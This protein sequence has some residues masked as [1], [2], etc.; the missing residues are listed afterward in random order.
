MPSVASPAPRPLSIPVPATLLRRHAF[1]SG[2]WPERL[3]S[4]IAVGGVLLSILLNFPV[5]TW[6]GSGSDF[7]TMYAS[8]SLLARGIDGYSFQNIAQTFTQQHVVQPASWYGHAPVYPPFTLALIAPLTALPMVAAVW[9]WV[10]LSG[11]VI[12]CAIASLARLA[13]QEFS[14]SRPWRLAVIALAAAWP[15]LSFGLEMGNVSVIVSALSI[16][17]VTAPENVG[18]NSPSLWLRSLGLA[19]ALLLKPHLAFWVLLALLLMRHRPARLLAVRAIALA[20]AGVAATSAWIA[21]QHDL[22]LQIHSYRAMLHS[23][24]AA[25]SM[26]SQTRNLEAVAAQITSLESLLGFWSGHLHAVGLVLLLAGFAALVAVSLR[27]SAAA[28]EARLGLVSA[29]CAF[30]LIA[31]YHRAHDCVVL[32]LMLPWLL[33]RVHASMRSSR[34]DRLAFP[35]LALAL[36]L[37]IAPRWET[38]QWLATMPIIG[39]AAN[40][41]LYRQAPVAAAILACLLIAHVLRIAFADRVAAEDSAQALRPIRA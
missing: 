10:I 6:Q 14:L 41:Q 11:F 2:Y 7:K 21:T 12:A 4:L 28:P 20:V 37:S 25:G 35:A 8:A 36:I 24:L 19:T 18:T 13:G 40:L 33:A 30:G 17:A 38:S 23:E 39:P 32:I 31:T 22:T 9:T 26:G 16:L 5:G 15:L 34:L 29:W 3:G 1:W 27:L